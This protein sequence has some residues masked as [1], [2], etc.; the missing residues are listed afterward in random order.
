MMTAPSRGPRSAAGTSGAGAGPGAGAGS[1]PPNELLALL[2]ETHARL[3]RRQPLPTSQLSALLVDDAA[4]A[5]PRDT[6]ELVIACA[7]EARD[8]GKWTGEHADALRRVLV[9]FHSV[10]PQKLEDLELQPIDF[11]AILARDRFQHYTDVRV[12]VRSVLG[13]ACVFVACNVPW[14]AAL[15]VINGGYVLHPTQ[16]GPPPNSSSTYTAES[17]QSACDF[18]FNFTF[19]FLVILVFSTAFSLAVAVARSVDQGKNWFSLRVAPVVAIVI[20]L[21]VLANSMFGVVTVWNNELWL[22][23]PSA[24]CA[25]LRSLAVA[26]ISV[27]LL[28]PIAC[29]V[30]SWLQRR[31]ARAP[32]GFR[33]DAASPA[34][35]NRAAF[36]AHAAPA[37]PAQAATDLV[38][39]A[40]ART[41]GAAEALQPALSFSGPSHTSGGA[42][43][44]TSLA[45]A[46][47][48]ARG[49]ASSGSASHPAPNAGSGDVSRI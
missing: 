3:E 5:A 22:G 17:L 16:L 20:S 32:H 4:T 2:L 14:I 31:P 6:R 1:A 21:T 18:V 44:A 11:P 48:A 10:P 47:A 49:A 40:T 46:A 43:N 45:A 27:F 7:R 34:S 26:A 30:L 38:N 8:R 35:A 37:P 13:W 36:G 23:F 39:P 29:I 12:C 9:D 33:G 28:V 19:G 41:G 24:Q 25:E 15:V 42:P